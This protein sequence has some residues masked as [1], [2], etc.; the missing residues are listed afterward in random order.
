MHSLPDTSN[1]AEN[2]ANSASTPYPAW[3]LSGSLLARALTIQQ[4]LPA[5]LGTSGSSFKFSQAV[6]A[7]KPTKFSSLGFGAALALGGWIIY[8]GDEMDG[9]GFN[10]AWSSLYLIVNGGASI[11]GLIRGRVSPVGLSLLAAGNAVLYGKKFFWPNLNPLKENG[12][13]K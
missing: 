5:N 3:I 7:Q 10:F 8:D 2:L 1:I 13:V 4:P 6:A 11:K 9:A 12:L